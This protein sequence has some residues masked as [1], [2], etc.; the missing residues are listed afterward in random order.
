[1]TADAVEQGALGRGLAHFKRGSGPPLVY[2][3]GLSSDHRPPHGIE[4]WLQRREVRPLSAHRTVWWLNRREGLEPDV[5]M[6]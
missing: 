4:R 1:M 6:A 2:L 3:A 5:T